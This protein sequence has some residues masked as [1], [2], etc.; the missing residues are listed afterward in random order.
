MPFTISHVA[1]VLPFSRYLKARQMLAAA[2]I[3]SMAPDFGIFLP[4]WHLLR[5]ETHA[6]FALV[7]FI[8]PAG[9]ASYWLFQFAIKP[10]MQA[11]LPDKAY[12]LARPFAAAA[13]IRKWRAWLL[14]AAGI[15]LGALTHL[16]WDAF[17]HE[18][19]RGMRMIPALDE[20]LLVVGSHHVAGQRLLQDVSSLVGFVIIGWWIAWG[21]H[22][23]TAPDT[24]SRPLGPAERATWILVYGLMAVLGTI[25]ALFLMHEAE[26]GRSALSSAAND[27]A[28]AGLRGLGFSLLVVSLVVDLR[29]RRRKP[30]QA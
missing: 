13:D 22:R 1:A 5:A 14:A 20:L 7:T 4:W 19:A 23:E 12:Q 21:L 26:P 3:G 8:L 30:A 16:L 27:A 28:V 25:A 24:G 15:L 6:R 18:G 17:T 11:V 2:V 10:A 9:L 29:L